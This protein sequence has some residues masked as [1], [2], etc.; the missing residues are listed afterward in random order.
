MSAQ[1]GVCRIFRPYW[2]F[3]ADYH[4]TIPDGGGVC[5][6]SATPILFTFPTAAEPPTNG[7]PDT[8]VLDLQ[9]AKVTP[10]VGTSPVLAKMMPVPLGATV[11][12]AIPAVPRGVGLS[13]DRPRFA[14]V[15]RVIFRNRSLAQALR[16]DK[17]FPYSLPK[18]SF[19][20]P[21]TRPESVP[22]RPNTVLA[23]ERTLIFGGA[24]AARLQRLSPSSNGVDQ[25]PVMADLFHDS[26][27]I[28]A[29]ATFLTGPPL[30]PGIKAQQTADPGGNY[31]TRLDYSQGAFDP[32]AIATIDG[33]DTLARAWPATG[34]NY[35]PF[36]TKAYGD[37]M[38]VECYKMQWTTNDD[39]ITFVPR[40]WEFLNE[41]GAIDTLAEDFWF[42]VLFGLGADA[43]GVRRPT[44]GA[45]VSVGQAPE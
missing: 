45:L 23:G 28:E 22:F 25:S 5:T 29:Q 9:A 13:Q 10:P 21:D 44:M 41:E 35:V 4:G 19:A 12:V 2:N 8:S 11:E 31:V 1:M 3:E 33:G 20:T 7:N 24:Q 38:A 40:N 36:V 39:L 34:I 14:Y 27:R 16:G 18:S 43:V 15:W 6:G 32:Q 26:V 30:Y 37:E 42:S 17:V